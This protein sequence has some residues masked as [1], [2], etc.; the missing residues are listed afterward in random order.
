MWEEC[1]AWRRWRRLSIRYI[2]LWHSLALAIYKSKAHKEF[3]S[4]AVMVR[5]HSTR[6]IRLPIHRN[7]F[8]FAN[9]LQSRRLSV[10]LFSSFQWKSLTT[11][12]CSGNDE[13]RDRNIRVSLIFLSPTRSLVGSPHT[14]NYTIQMISARKCYRIRCVLAYGLVTS[15]NPVRHE[16]MPWGVDSVA[17]I[18]IHLHKHKCTHA[19]R[20][21]RYA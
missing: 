21:Y 8:Y 12:Q 4:D 18:F 16:I 1:G 9:H 14:N 7:Y 11:R 5:A 20:T 13:Q 10:V 2:A 6:T 17:F 15:A 3:T 19:L